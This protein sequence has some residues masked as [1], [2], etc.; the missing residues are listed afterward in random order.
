MAGK[1][2]QAG[3]K[4]ERVNLLF[5]M[6]PGIA[7]SKPVPW[8]SFS[9]RPQPEGAED[10]IGNAHRHDLL[11]GDRLLEFFHAGPSAHIHTDK[12]ALW[13]YHHRIQNGAVPEAN[14]ED[15]GI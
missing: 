5:A 14:G 11:W 1:W 10:A 7:E 6:G 9:P 3:D 4:F 12:F 2:F 15:P 8:L 13:A